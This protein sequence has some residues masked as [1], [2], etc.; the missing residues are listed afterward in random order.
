MRKKTKNIIDSSSVL[1]AHGLQGNVV[2]NVKVLGQV[3]RNGRYYPIEVMQKALPKYN[4][5]VVN[6]DH[7]P[8]EPRSVLERF[9]RI[10][11]PRLEADGIYG[12][13]EYNT[14]HAWAKA[15]EYFVE[16][17]PDAIGLSHAAIA[18]T[19]MDHK[20]GQEVVEDITELDSVDIVHSAATNKN[21]FESYNL[22]MESLMKKKKVSEATLV[23]PGKH[24]HVPEEEKGG[25]MEPQLGGQVLGE[26]DG[27]DEKPEA[28]LGGKEVG[29]EKEFDSYEA[30]CDH[31]K[32]E[33]H[34]IM[35][36]HEGDHDT[37]VEKMMELMMPKDMD[38]KAD[39][40][41]VPDDVMGLDEAED[42]TKDDDD[43]KKKAEES[44]RHSKKVGFKLLLEELDSYRV[45]ERHVKNVIKIKDYCKKAGL[46]DK[47][48]TEAFIDVLESVPESKWKK[49]VEDRKS[50]V[51]V[52][53]QPISFGADVT[54]GHKQLT[55]DE[56]VKAL[57]S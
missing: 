38:M 53:K 12:D 8:N 41:A 47:L 20:S 24:V 2:K 34:N 42:E 29:E 32:K 10:I 21:L 27:E 3:S 14:G 36:N 43:A 54:Q 17:Q 40:G 13:L 23:M 46:A 57:R 26:D 16:Y 50:I 22:I 48:V 39:E 25:L 4:G 5:V 28:E 19:K 1:E 51:A 7:K 56:L 15:F 55:V 9:G 18:K 49:L 33:M 44:I 52:S 45:R 11:N 35:K 37:A 6:L 31:M 30:Y